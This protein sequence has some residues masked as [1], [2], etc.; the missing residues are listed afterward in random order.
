[1]QVQNNVKDLIE[2]FVSM[3]KK[4]LSLKNNIVLGVLILLFLMVTFNK[5]LGRIKLYCMYLVFVSISILVFSGDNDHNPSKS[6]D[7]RGQCSYLIQY[8]TY[9]IY[10]LPF[11]F[12]S[13]QH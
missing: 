6:I 13:K 1:M 10:S 4:M 8:S 2:C 11:F 3:S 5:S 12:I 7:Q 9:D